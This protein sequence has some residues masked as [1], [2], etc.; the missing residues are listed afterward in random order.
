MRSEK[1]VRR[2]HVRVVQRNSVHNK[3]RRL[4]NQRRSDAHWKANTFFDGEKKLKVVVEA[5]PVR[6]PKQ[7]KQHTGESIP[8]PKKH[9]DNQATAAAAK[10]ERAAQEKKRQEEAELKKQQQK[11]KE[12]EKRAAKEQQ[13]R[14]KAA[15]EEAEREAKEQ[16]KKERQAREKVEREAREQE[17]KKKRE[18]QRQEAE[19]VKAEKAEA[20]RLA[21]ETAA[22]EAKEREEQKRIAR[23][24][25]QKREEAERQEAARI[26]QEKKEQDEAEARRSLG[27]FPFKL[28][29]SCRSNR[30]V[31]LAQQQNGPVVDHLVVDVAATNNGPVEPRMKSSVD[32]G[33]EIV[34]DANGKNGSN[35]SIVEERVVVSSS[36]TATPR[37]AK[38]ELQARQTE[39]L[40]QIT[41]FVSYAQARLA[42]SQVV[43]SEEPRKTYTFQMPTPLPPRNVEPRKRER[44]HRL[45]PQDVEFCVYMMETYGEDYEGMS[46]DPKNRYQDD[47]RSLQRKLRIFKNSVHFEEYQAEKKAAAATA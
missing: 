46:K 22:K 39:I 30:T 47:A 12:A 13:R 21:K 15:R 2:P 35:G 43:H 42:Q 45:L 24:E 34:E 23:E 4:K 3:F 33:V 6:Q 20:D 37:S 32:S 17:E 11:E 8:K 44:A 26:A 27:S 10:A 19:R 7:P 25:Q 9:V 1:A 16:E 5:A 41:E 38:D 40:N 36:G 14:E 29:L 18:A 31:L 28:R